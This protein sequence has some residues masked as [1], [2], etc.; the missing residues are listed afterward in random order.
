MIRSVKTSDAGS[1]RWVEEYQ[2]LKSFWGVT[3]YL[4]RL[5]GEKYAQ[6][7]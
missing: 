2:N 7:F 6:Y 3:P 4:E 1:E 5:L